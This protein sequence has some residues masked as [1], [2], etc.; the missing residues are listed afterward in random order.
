VKN[1]NY[2]GDTV[3]GSSIDSPANCARQQIFVAVMGA[4]NFPYVEPSGCRRSAR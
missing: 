3:S 2:A 4:S 1:H